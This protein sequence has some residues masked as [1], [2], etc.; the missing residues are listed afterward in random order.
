MNTTRTFCELIEGW[1]YIAKWKTMG[2]S[3]EPYGC[4]HLHDLACLLISEN[5]LPKLPSFLVDIET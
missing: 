2:L 1:N 4:V 3:R 5:I